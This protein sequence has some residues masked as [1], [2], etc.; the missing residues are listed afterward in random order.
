MLLTCNIYTLYTTL[1][2]TTFEYNKLRSVLNFSGVPTPCTKNLQIT[3]M[4]DQ[5]ASYF[6]YLRN[7]PGTGDTLCRTGSHEVCKNACYVV[8]RNFVFIR[9][10]ER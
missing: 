7:L 3:Y 10:H 9:T 2:T 6:N 1:C 8:R 4:D 5:C